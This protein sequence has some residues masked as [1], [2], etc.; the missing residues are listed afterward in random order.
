[1]RRGE[2]DRAPGCQCRIGCTAVGDPQ[3]H[4]VTDLIW[5]GRRCEGDPGLVSGWAS[6]AHKQ[7]PG[8]RELEHD[9]RAAVLPV[10]FRAQDIYPEVTRGRRVSD[11][12]NVRDRDVGAERTGLLAHPALPS[13][14]LTCGTDAPQDRR[15][16]HRGSTRGHLCLAYDD[17]DYWAWFHTGLDHVLDAGPHLVAP[18]RVT[19]RS[20][21]SEA[22]IDVEN[23]WLFEIADGNF[24]RAQLYADTAAGRDT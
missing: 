24:V 5:V 6:S 10:Q 3:R 8:P 12:E 7:K 16:H 22:T 17:H 15:C 1:M 11:D 9:A 2:E 21:S 20:K 14:C 4:G 13:S 18:I 23:L 19:A